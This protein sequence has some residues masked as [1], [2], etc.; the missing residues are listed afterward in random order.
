MKKIFTIR[1]ILSTFLLAFVWMI[2]IIYKVYCKK[3]DIINFDL[4][5]VLAILGGLITLFSIIVLNKL[6]KESFFMG[7]ISATIYSLVH[8]IN[9]SCNSEYQKSLPFLFVKIQN[10]YLIYNINKLWKLMIKI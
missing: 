5:K 7:I 2:Y 4:F 8:F 9:K 1:N 10:F 3:L 6:P